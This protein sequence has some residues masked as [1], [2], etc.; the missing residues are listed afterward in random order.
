MECQHC[1][2]E[3]TSI[4]SLRAHVVTCPKNPDRKYRNG[5]LG[6]TAWNKGLTKD[7]NDIVQHAA[8]KLVGKLWQGTFTES[9]KKKLSDSAKERGLGGYRPHPNRGT[10]YNGTWFDSKWEVRVAETLDLHGIKWERP[11][12]GFVWND[13]GN[14]Y[15]PDFYLPDYE[16]YLD[17]KNSYLQ[18]ADKQKIESATERNGIRVL[19]LSEEQLDWKIIALMV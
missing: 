3:K 1:G 6:K 9:S 8:A 2:Q 16:V 18:K 5:M 15:Y 10:R 4:K 11:R 13:H 12:T 14:K 17:P 7:T 19:V